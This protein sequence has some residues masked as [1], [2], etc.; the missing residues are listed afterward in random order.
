MSRFTSAV[1]LAVGAVVAVGAYRAG[2]HGTAVAVALVTF[3]GVLAEGRA[4]AR[5]ERRRG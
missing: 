1:L 4:W 3:A 2:A 5:R